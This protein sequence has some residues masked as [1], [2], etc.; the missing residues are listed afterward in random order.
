MTPDNCPKCGAAVKA[1]PNAASYTCP[2]CKH[3]LQLEVAKPAPPPGYGPPPAGGYGPPPQVIVFHNNSSP[4][5]IVY[6]GGSGFGAYWTFRLIVAV[7]VISISGGGWLIRRFVRGSTG[8]GLAGDLGGWDGTSP[9]M[10]GGNDQIDVSGIN[11]T[12]TS[13][14]A[15]LAGGNCHVTCRD[16]TLKAPVGVEAGGN[17]QVT[18]MNGS[19]PGTDAA[20]SAGGNATINVLGNATVVGTTRKGGNASVTGVTAA[21]PAA[22]APPHPVAVTIPPATTQAPGPKPAVAPPPPHPVPGRPVVPAPPPR[23]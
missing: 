14:S 12:F 20:L 17:A 16:C 11:A 23:H 4:T 18:I 3:T 21:Q 6:S 9:L 1:E 5:P 13:G 15:I 19:V 7:V 22:V 2:Y 10:C 8:V